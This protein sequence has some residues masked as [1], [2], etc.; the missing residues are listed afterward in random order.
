MDTYVS[1][2]KSIKMLD[3]MKKVIH[4]LENKIQQSSYTI[5]VEAYDP[6]ALLDHVMKVASNANQR[7]DSTSP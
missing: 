3:L 6:M 5:V 2:S 1:P 7:R 4:C